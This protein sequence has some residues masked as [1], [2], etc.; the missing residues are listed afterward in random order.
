MERPVFLY[1]EDSFYWRVGSR[2][3]LKDPL[4]EALWGASA[5]KGRLFCILGSFM[6]CLNARQL[7][8]TGLSSP[9]IIFPGEEKAERQINGMQIW[10]T[11]SHGVHDHRKLQSEGFQVRLRQGIFLILRA[12]CWRKI[13]CKGRLWCP[14][15][16]R[17]YRWEKVSPQAWVP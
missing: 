1:C 17:T 10:K 2:E 6:P 7:Y 15:P 4:G 8:F 11:L 13:W 3:V 5:G 9:G 14:L 16:G 12:Y